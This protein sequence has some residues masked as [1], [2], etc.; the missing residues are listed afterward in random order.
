MRSFVTAVTPGAL[1]AAQPAPLRSF[2]VGMAG[3]MGTVWGSPSLRT[4]RKPTLSGVAG[5]R[6]CRVARSVRQLVAGRS[7]SSAP[8]TGAAIR[9][10]R[11]LVVDDNRDAALMLASALS[12]YGHDVRIAHDRPAAPTTPRTRRLGVS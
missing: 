2:Q 3:G 8:P 9:P 10:T 4:P 6:H 11:V 12:V 5:C 7:R 1:H